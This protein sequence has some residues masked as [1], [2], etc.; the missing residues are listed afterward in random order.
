MFNGLIKSLLFLGSFSLPTVKSRAA[1]VVL[2]EVPGGGGRCHS[3]PCADGIHCRTHTGEPCRQFL[4]APVACLQH[5]LNCSHT[6]MLLSIVPPSWRYG[7]CTCCSCANRR[8]EHCSMTNAYTSHTLTPSHFTHPHIT[9]THTHTQS[10]LDEFD[11]TVHSLASDLRD[12][13]RL[14]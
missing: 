8:P 7:A 4:P 3:S 10:A 11:Y 9:H 5:V 2:T 12:G 6:H 14:T 13:L 1:S